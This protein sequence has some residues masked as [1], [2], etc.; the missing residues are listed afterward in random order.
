M[1]T[2]G[3]GSADRRPLDYVEFFATGDRA[4]GEYHCSECGYG[5]TVYSA[6]PRCPM[7]GGGSWE[8]TAWSP[9]T[10]ERMAEGMATVVARTAKFDS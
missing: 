2:I 1:S 10:R 8:H 6:L 5:V 4:K 9:F 3:E 7:C